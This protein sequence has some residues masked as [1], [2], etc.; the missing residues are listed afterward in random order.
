MI[1]GFTSPIP[2][3][4]CFKDKELQKTLGNVHGRRA[5]CLTELGMDVN[6]AQQLW[7]I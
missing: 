2:S 3:R 4:V 7:G 1:L 5:P 6:K